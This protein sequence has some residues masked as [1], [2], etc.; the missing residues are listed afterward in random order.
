MGVKSK[1]SMG[2]KSM[3]VKSK[4]SMGVKIMG[5]KSRGVKAGV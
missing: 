5:V 2:V 4:K 1:K 3:G